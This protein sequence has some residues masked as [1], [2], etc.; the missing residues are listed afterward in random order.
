MPHRF[1][2][3][4]TLPAAPQTVY[5]C[6]LDSAG[7]SAMTGGAATASDRI[8]GAFTAW[9]GYISGRNLALEPG[10]RIVQSWRTT[11]FAAADPDSIVTLTLAPVAGGV[12]LTLEHADV[13]DGDAHKGYENG[14]WAD[15]YFTPMRA[16]F[17]G[18]AGAA[19][20]S[21]D[22]PKGTP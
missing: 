17:A 10:R 9:D 22:M 4:T 20:G 2:L 7:H 5:D 1:T 16:Y 15:H 13:P 6:W 18:Q 3:S 21:F 12:A 19:G 11:R 8:G 14:G